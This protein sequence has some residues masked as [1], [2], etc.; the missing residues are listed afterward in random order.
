MTWLPANGALLLVV[1][2]VAAVVV[3]VS[4]VLIITLLIP[5]SVAHCGV[6]FVEVGGAKVVSSE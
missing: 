2:A 6:H 4:S 5:R 1:A 3:V